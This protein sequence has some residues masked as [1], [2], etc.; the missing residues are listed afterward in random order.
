MSGIYIAAEETL[1][2]ASAAEF[3]PR[4]VRSL[5]FGILA[6]ANAVGDMVSSIA[7]GALLHLGM[8]NLAFG[9]AAGCG[10][11]GVLWLLRLTWQRPAIA[12]A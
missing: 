6:S 12:S 1:E 11:L 7:V 10:F 5:G 8:P 3:L 4:A 2:K 9:A